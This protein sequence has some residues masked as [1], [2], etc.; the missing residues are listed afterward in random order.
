MRQKLGDLWL[1]S[2]AEPLLLVPSVLMPLPN[3][4]D[5]NLLINHRH[6]DTPRIKIVRIVPFEL[7]P[8]LFLP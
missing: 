6:P 7:D 2:I 8:R 1:D 4:P 3:A 5:R